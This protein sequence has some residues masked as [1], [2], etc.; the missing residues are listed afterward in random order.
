MSTIF[1]LQAKSSM[2]DLYL[3]IWSI[4][5]PITALLSLAHFFPN[6]LSYSLAGI[7][8]V[9]LMFYAFV[10]FSFTA[11]SQRRRGVYD[12]LHATPMPLYQ[13][14][15]SISIANALV[16]VAVSS[17]VLMIG[18]FISDVS[19]SIMGIVLSLPVLFVSAVMYLFLSFIVSSIVKT[20]GHLSMTTNLIMLPM[21]LGSSAFYSLSDAHAIVQWLQVLNPFEW[22]LSGIRAAFTMDFAL[23]GQSLL[24]L[25]IFF[26]LFFVGSIKTFSYG[27]R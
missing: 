15:L 16:A 12:L 17:F 19:N 21:I 5:I 25:F 3:V 6:Y 10:T 9:S 4:V 23:W 2:K 22:F 27:R 14:I 7:I 26:S 13:Y 18:L 20:E 1:L 24:F 11:L 8:A